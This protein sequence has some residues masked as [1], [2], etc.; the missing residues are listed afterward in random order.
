V[1][2]SV[3]LD[4]AHQVQGQQAV[5][6]PTRGLTGIATAAV[7]W[8]T[9]AR[10]LTAGREDTMVVGPRARRESRRTELRQARQERLERLR[11]DTDHMTVAEL[12]HEAGIAAKVDPG[13][14][15]TLL[16]AA[17]RRRPGDLGLLWD[18][19]LYEYGSND[20]T[21]CERTLRVLLDTH[22]GELGAIALLEKVLRRL[23][24]SHEASQWYHRRQQLQDALGVEGSG[25]GSSP[26]HIA[27][28]HLPNADRRPGPP[29]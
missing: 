8:E 7:A 12:R 15:I 23:G 10:T 5:P 3:F 24:R 16:K 22:C 21:G 27:N 29:P 25:P 17:L 18:K 6:E 9:T 14:A 13:L 20:L 11:A 1:N 28:E 4:S 19:A 2:R 26:T